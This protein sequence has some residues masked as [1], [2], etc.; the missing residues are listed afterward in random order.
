MVCLLLCEE[1]ALTSGM[2]ATRPVSAQAA[3]AQAR[4]YEA[5]QLLALQVFND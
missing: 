1:L 5:D 3:Q 2:E 4:P